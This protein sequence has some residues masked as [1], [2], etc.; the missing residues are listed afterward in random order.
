MAHRDGAIEELVLADGPIELTVLPGVGAR[1]HRLRVFGRDLIR[2][3]AE[4]SV[5]I[6]DPFFW[7]SYVMAPWC[8][9]LSADRVDVGSRRV[10]L[11]S[12]FPDGTAIHGQ[13]YAR[14]WEHDGH[15]ELWIRGGGDGWPWQ[16]EVRQ[17]IAVTPRTIGLAL[18]LTNRSDDPMPAG[19]GIHPWFM[20]PIQVGIHAASVFPTNLDSQPIPDPVHG[21]FDRREIG[22]MADGLDASWADL[23]DPPVELVWPDAGIRAT[24]R[25]SAPTG[26]IVAANPPGVD[27]IAV[28][29]ETHAPQG[30]RRL[31]GHEPGGLTLLEPGHALN[32]DVEL[33]FDRL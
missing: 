15:G 29:P 11:G 13:V 10:E 26:Y 30:L 14:P 5:H 28:E 12:N 7:G 9:R 21:P 31:L 18:S 4:P 32:L 20:R 8:N 6:R 1:L 2:T 22:E 25:M 3:P 17:R 33:A 24:M 19:I 23:A 27:A 16:Y